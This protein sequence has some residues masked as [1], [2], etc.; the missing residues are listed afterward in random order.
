MTIFGKAVNQNGRKFYMVKNSWGETGE[1]KGIWYVSEN[2]VKG[3]T[4]NILINKNAIPKDI[5]KKLGLK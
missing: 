1:Y 4:M 3:R 5:A 2:Y